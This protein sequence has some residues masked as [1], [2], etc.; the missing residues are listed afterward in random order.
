MKIDIK[1]LKD[2]VP[3]IIFRQGLDYFK[4]GRVKIKQTDNLSVM[5]T[6]HG[7]YPYV[8]RLVVD[9]NSFSSSCT[10][11][12][13]Y[14]CKHA[15]AVALKVIEDQ[16][17]VEENEQ[18][19]STNWREYFEKLIAIQQVDSDFS[20]EV[21]WK[22][23]YIIHITENYWNIKPVK[24]YMKKDGTYGRVQ[25]PSF[26][27]L[28]AQ[29]VFRTS[30]DLIAISYLERLQSQQSSV[31]FRGRLETSYL[32]FGLDAGQIFNLLRL[33][34]LHIKNEDGSI[35]TRIRFGRKPWK[36]RFKLI[37]DET[38]YRFQPYFQR[39]EEEVPI[40]QKANILTVNPI[41]F[42]REGKLYTCDFPLSYSYIKSFVDE[43]LQIGLTKDEYHS[44]ISDYLAKLPIFPYVDFPPGIEVHEIHD[45]AASRLYI[46]EM[47]DQLVV[48]L[49]FMY[50]NIEIAFSQSNDQFLQYDHETSQI[51]R[52]HRDMDMEQIQREKVLDSGIVEDTPG[53]FYATFEDSLEWLFD[54]LPKLAEQGFEIL[55]EESLVRF[56]VKRAR[57]DFGVNISSETDWF[58]IE[59]N[60]EFDGVPVSL[61][62]LKKALRA[63][64]K[65]VKLRDGTI[66]RL[67]QKLIEKFNYMINFGKVDDNSIRFANH[68]MT[69]VDKLLSEADSKTLDLMS[70]EKLQKLDKFDKIK[71]YKLPDNFNGELRDY[72]KAG[73]DWLNFLKDFSFGGILADDM[74]LGKTIQTLCLLNNIVNIDPKST[75][76]IIAP[77]SVIFNWV[78]EIGR[79]APHLTYLV[80]YG[81]RR[82]KDTRRLKKYNLVLTTYGHLRRDVTFLK[83]MSFNYIILDES[84]NIKNPASETSKAVRLLEGQNRLALTGT[85]VEN[86]TMDLWAQFAFVSPGLLGDQNFFK[87]TFMRPIEKEQNVQ[88]ADTLKR[89]I[90]PFILRRTKEDVAKELPPKVES[91]T[92]SPMSDAQQALYDK[93]RL[94]YRDNILEEIE[95]KGLN[96]SKFKV[97]EGLTKLRQ[98]AC[99]PGLISSSFSDNSGKFDALKEMVE[100]I[101]SENHKVLIFSQFVQMLQIIKRYFDEQKIAYSY[102]DGSTKDRQGA[103]KSFQEDDSVRTFLISLKAGGT[104]LNLTAADYVIHYDPWWNPAVEMQATDRAYRIGQT[105][106]VFAYK[107]ISKDSVEEKIL[108]LQQSKRELV[109]SLISTE[110][111][112]FKSLSKND[113]LELFE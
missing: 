50:E 44:F 108:K 102:L 73:Y 74:G 81:T 3:D 14:V 97:L 6:V 1:D 86:N 60:L 33:S 104:G 37:S 34:E 2:K 89:L 87:D 85:P 35:G 99:H 36:L 64:K 62:E 52:V 40:D 11:P 31:Y 48:S 47:D 27:E 43:K 8:T 16:S 65:Y 72:Q 93:W 41:W 56:R 111:T 4:D 82:S 106:K 67:P 25:E 88:V 17:A 80:H 53:L 57:A 69:F 75:S 22:L 71:A 39:D 84:Q 101:I 83:D 103:V 28:S 59:L 38:C 21:R 109:E 107:L 68:H 98:I 91:I 54:G 29:N 95:S 19:E 94:S 55:G 15:V 30:G 96:K 113:I 20:Q 13:K 105:R 63:Q 110:E 58:D 42:Y 79:F 26:N 112:F 49:A 66:A 77:T 76:I 70:Q 32:K 24:V 10:C 45:V 7:T 9:G 5:A 51:I 12:Y 61:E 23:I 92:F 100:E 46:E 90:F 18:V 78:S